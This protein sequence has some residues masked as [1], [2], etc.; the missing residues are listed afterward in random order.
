LDFGTYQII[1]MLVSF[2]FSLSFHES[3]HAYA[4]LYLGDSFAAEQG[5]ISLNPVVHIDPIGTIVMPL[6]MIFTGVPLIG[7]AKPVP[8]TGQG[9]RNPIRDHCLVAVAG[10]VSNLVL[11]V[12]GTLIYIVLMVVVRNVGFLEQAMGG[13]IPIFLR[14]LFQAFVQINLLLA[15]FNMIPVHPLDGSWVAEYVL[16]VE[17][18]ESY[19]RL[20]PF[21]FFILM[22]LVITGIFRFLILPPL[23][24]LYGFF[25]AVARIAVGG[26]T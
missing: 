23:S 7:W 16:P 19:R 25:D 9:F 22:G 21:G 1:L 17:L 3:A 26:L 13:N 8:V 11:V 18:R 10:P 15:L 6:L 12:L 20:R 4:A 2:L 14:M 24:L 5:R